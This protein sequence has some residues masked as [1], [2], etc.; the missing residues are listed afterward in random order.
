MVQYLV[1]PMVILMLWITYDS[2][3]IL[4]NFAIAKSNC[5][6][7]LLSSVVLA[8]FFQINIIVIFHVLELYLDFEYKEVMERLLAQAECKPTFWMTEEDRIDKQLQLNLRGVYN[9]S[10]S[11]QMFFVVTLYTCAMYQF[12]NGIV[13]IVSSNYNLF[14]D[15]YTLLI[16]LFWLA[17][18][19][20]S[21]PLLKK[22]ISLL[23]IWGTASLPSSSTQEDLSAT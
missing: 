16:L 21:L 12:I 10:I 7:Y 6:L 14:K 20:L 5:I 9:Y 17:T 8:I 23:N 1:Q 11:S 4:R 15:P 22:L 18:M 2:S 19:K 13:T 3:T